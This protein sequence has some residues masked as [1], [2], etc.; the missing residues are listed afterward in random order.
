MDHY[1][2]CLRALGAYLR[3]AGSRWTSRATRGNGGQLMPVYKRKYRSGT[4]LWFYKF[5]SP[6]ATRG[7]L[8][9]RKFGFATKREAEDAEAQRRIDEQ[10]KDE[11]AKAGAGVAAPLPRTLAMLLEEVFCEHA[12]KKVEPQ[13][14]ER[15]RERD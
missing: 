15:Y 4:I 9:V 8:P 6:G 2:A 10:H 13:T 5:P 7:S 12:E 1:A 14:A 3:H 11:L